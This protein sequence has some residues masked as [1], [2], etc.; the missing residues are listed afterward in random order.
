MKRIVYLSEATRPFGDRELTELLNKARSKNHAAGLSGLLV[1]HDNLFFQILEGPAHAVDLCFERIRMD[2]RHCNLRVLEAGAVRS[3]AFPQWRMG[4]SRP[5]RLRPD[6]RDGVFSIF[7]MVPRNSPL[8]G[9][10]ANVRNHVRR[11][12]ASFERLNQIG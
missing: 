2:Q 8:R 1:F 7:D 12:L 5:E 4:F 6:Q 10:D 11:F 9:E 3:R